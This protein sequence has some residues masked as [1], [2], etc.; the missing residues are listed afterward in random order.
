MKNVILLILLITS[1]SACWAPRCPIST[2]DVSMEHRHA[3]PQGTYSGR[4]I[5][6]KWRFH[7][8]LSKKEREKRKSGDVPSSE[9]GLKR[10]KKGPKKLFDWERE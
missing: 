10:K 1:L 4:P 8:F 2:C 3:V 5:Y 6:S 7:N 9:S